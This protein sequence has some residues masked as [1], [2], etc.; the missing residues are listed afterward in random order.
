M[1]YTTGRF[2]FSPVFFFVLILFSHFSI[3]IISLEEERAGLYASCASFYFTRV[4][5][6]PFY[7][8]LGVRGWL[9]LVIVAL[10]GLFYYLSFILYRFHQKLKLGLEFIKCLY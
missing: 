3:V 10:P 5:H 9:R 6:C 2:M 4:N 8:P 7:L 1:V